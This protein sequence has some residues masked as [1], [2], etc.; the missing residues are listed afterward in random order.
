MFILPIFFVHT[1]ILCSFFVD[2]LFILRYSSFI[3]SVLYLFLFFLVNSYHGSL[4]PSFVLLFV[5]SVIFRSLF[6][7]SFFLVR[8]IFDHSSFSSLFV[9]SFPH[10]SLD[11]YIHP[12]LYQCILWFLNLFILSLIH[13][14]LFFTHFCSLF[15]YSSFI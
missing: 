6:V 14:R 1:F 10:S 2:P 11:S 13:F 4:V 5:H 9:L 12:F 3:Q 7:H 8:F 15:V